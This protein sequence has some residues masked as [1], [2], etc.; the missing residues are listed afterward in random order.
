LKTGILLGLLASVLLAGCG[1]DSMRSSQPAE[2]GVM[3]LV[4]DAADDSTGAIV[5][6][7]SGAAIDSI[8]PAGVGVYG[9][10]KVD[11]R[12]R[13]SRARWCGVR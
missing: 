2:P 12:P 6:T 13:C 4:F 8:V 11:A 7:V 5:V 10:S 1:G 9:S 3:S